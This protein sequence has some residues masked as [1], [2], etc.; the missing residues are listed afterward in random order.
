MLP[1]KEQ[2]LLHPAHQLR[3]VL[4]ERQRLVVQK[5][6]VFIQHRLQPVAGVAHIR[7]PVLY[8]NLHI[9]GI[10]V[11]IVTP[12]GCRSRFLPDS[13]LNHL[14]ERPDALR[15]IGAL[16]RAPGKWRFP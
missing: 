12:G 15:F 5:L 6:G 9:Y 13:R 11:D 7:T 16:G 4:R 8:T 2:E 10:S 3:L 14:T 1:R